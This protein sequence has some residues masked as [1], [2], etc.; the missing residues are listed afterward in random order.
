M[1]KDKL[2]FQPGLDMPAIFA[3]IKRDYARENLT[4]VDGLKIDW[5][6]AWVHL[7][8]SNTE[9]VVRIYAEARTP[10]EAETK[11]KE[12]KDKIFAYIK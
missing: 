7:R 5:P 4:E 12:I 11:V 3:A 1:V 9:P 10:G 8:T 2:Q 6:E